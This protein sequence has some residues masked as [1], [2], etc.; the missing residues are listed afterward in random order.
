MKR[1]FY[2]NITYG[3]N[4]NCIFCYSHNTWHNSLPHNEIRV[5]SFFSYL[6]KMKLV[7]D[8]RVIVNGGE[9]LLHTQIESILQGLR[10]YQCEVLVYTNGRLLTRGDYSLLNER[11]RFVIPIHGTEVVHD[12]ITGISG[13]YKETIAGLRH[14]VNTSNC[15]VDIKLILNRQLMDADPDGAKI[16]NAFDTEIEFNNAVHLTKMADTIVSVRRGC[17]SVSYEEAAGFMKIYFDYFVGRNVEVKLFDTCVKDIMDIDK[18]DKQGFN[19]EIV[20]F[21]KDYS[22]F[23]VMDL[24]RQFPDCYVKCKCKNMCLS[25]VDEYKALVFNNGEFYEELE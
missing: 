4:S 25:A 9:P 21:F 22:Q 2:F 14:L 5:E 10:K 24:S 8:D 17:S 16:K 23:R 3:C 19:E 18:A 7:S 15:L 1:I 6:D 12:S 20:V 13:S 11:F